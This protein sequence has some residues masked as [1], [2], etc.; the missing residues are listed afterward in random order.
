[1]FDEQSVR[2][3]VEAAYRHYIDVF[4]QRNRAAFVACFESSHSQLIGPH[5][6]AL[7][8]DHDKF[9]KDLMEGLDE[10]QWGRSGIDRMEVVAYSNSLAQLIVDLTRYRTDGSVLE[11]PYGIYMYRKKN[12]VWRVVSATAT[13]T[14]IA[15]MSD[16]VPG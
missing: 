6:I 4:N 3:E 8:T 16:I 10:V 12:G 14:P 2:H 7:I 5:P 1:M 11:R 9:Y 13:E 15:R